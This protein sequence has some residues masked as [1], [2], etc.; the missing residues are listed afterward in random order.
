MNNIFRRIVCN[1]FTYNEIRD[2]GSGL[3]IK[4]L[5]GT[6]IYGKSRANKREQREIPFHLKLFD[7]IVFEGGGKHIL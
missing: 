7:I 5:T 3:R 6:M 4:N 1:S 2:Q